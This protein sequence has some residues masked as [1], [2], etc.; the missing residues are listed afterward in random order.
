[1]R[2][3]HAGF[4]VD[5]LGQAIQLYESLGFS[6]KDRFEKPEPHAFVATVVDENGIG[7]EL[8]QFDGDHP[9]NE[10]IGRHL[11]F[12]CDDARRAA[13]TL[14][15][16]GFHEVIPYTEGV[17]LNYVFVSDNCGTVFE[18]AEEK[19]TTATNKSIVDTANSLLD[20][21]KQDFTNLS[22]R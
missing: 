1:M 13:A 22:Q 20:R 16:C 17:K 14:L 10:Y 7:L 12:M 21:Y 3:I 19:T 18:L 11:A 4:R 15:Q 8:W 2:I 5:D 6:L 9:L